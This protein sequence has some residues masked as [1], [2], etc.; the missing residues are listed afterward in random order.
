[1]SKTKATLKRS[2]KLLNKA[3]DDLLRLKKKSTRQH[4][5]KPTKKKQVAEE[6]ILKAEAKAAELLAEVETARAEQV[7]KELEKAL[8]RSRKSEIG[9]EHLNKKAEKA[10]KK[11][12]ARQSEVK[13]VEEKYAEY[14]RVASEAMRA[15]NE[16]KERTRHQGGTRADSENRETKAEVTSINIPKEAPKTTSEVVKELSDQVVES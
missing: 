6:D 13:A 2:V 9:V 8:K 4:L 12:R 1:M 11:L 16:K 7:K 3:Q 14:Q 15:A 10:L 5:D